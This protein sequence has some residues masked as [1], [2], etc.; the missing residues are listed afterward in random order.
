MQRRNS[1][2]NGNLVALS[3]LAVVFTTVGAAD[4]TYAQIECGDPDANEIATN[5]SLYYE[6]WKNE[7]YRTALP[8]LR[9]ILECAPGYPNNS[10]RNFRRAIDA[11]E[12]IA[13]TADS[14]EMT[15]AYMDSTLIL[16][17]TAPDRLAD[18]G[19]DVD[20]V[21]WK[22]SKARF[23]QEH[24]EQLPELQDEIGPMYLEIYNEDR[25]KLQSY[26]INYIIVDFVQKNMKAD[27]VEFM[28]RVESDYPDD[29]ELQ[30]MINSYR[31]QLFTSPEER[32]AF[33]ESQLEA[34]PDDVEL[35][36]ELFE[37]YQDEGMRDR[38]YEMAPRI[39]EEN[40]TPE[41][42]RMIAKMRLDDGDTQE[43]IRLY[44]ESLDMEGGQDGAREVY[45]NI[46]LAHQQDGRL[47]N[48]RTSFRRALEMDPDY[49]Q[50]LIAIGDLYV[51]AVQGCDTFERLDRAVYWLATDYF[52]RAAA[53]AGSD[54]FRNQARQRVASIREYYPTEEHK[55]FSNWSAG[56]RYVINYGCYTWINEATTVR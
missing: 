14:E 15:R 4:A 39:M 32:M 13:L 27:A 50:A 34:S 33:L 36:T 56:D 20:R 17:D 28:D 22:F 21:D 41:T 2:L 26:Y 40:P 11:Y 25:S 46:G 8:Y 48:A 44:E 23:V 35:L 29:Q 37:L 18:A 6:D 1:L 52:E 51:T 12:G 38:V 10:D 7:S 43:A 31:G 30:S 49:A 9:W 16:F 55:F 54:T 53:R 42:F 24:A 3:M 45:Y 5:Y 47:S 19:I